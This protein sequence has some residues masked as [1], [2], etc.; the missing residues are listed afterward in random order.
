MDQMIVAIRKY[1]HDHKPGKT[2]SP[3][4]DWPRS[5]DYGATQNQVLTRAACREGS[6]CCHFADILDRIPPWAKKIVEEGS[7]FEETDTA[8][9]KAKKLHDVKTFIEQN[10]KL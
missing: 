9:D 2:F 8:D 5:C 4:I 3:N 10:R 6:K 7:A 1:F